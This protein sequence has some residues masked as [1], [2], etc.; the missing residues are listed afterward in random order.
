[1]KKTALLIAV[2]VILAGFLV[3]GCIAIGYIQGTG[4]IMTKTFDFKDFTSVEISSS[5]EYEINYSETYSVSVS[6]HENILSFLDLSQSGKTLFVRL[7]SG[8]FT[9]SDTKA[10]ITLPQLDR[11][12]V[13]GASRGVV[14]GFKSTNNLELWVSGASQMETNLESGVTRLEISGASRTNGTLNAQ[15]AR[16]NI[17]GASRAEI[18]GSAGR[19]DISISGASHFN[20]ED[21]RM[22]NATVSVSGAS[23]A[24]IYTS[25]DL[26][27][28]A[29]GASSIDYYGEPKLKSVDVSGASRITK[30]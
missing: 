16:I 2:M 18:N 17:S 1:M 24:Q 5:F 28:D 19:G 26:S 11:V 20:S 22:Q 15:E 10:K 14:Q 30:K 4:P 23:H 27:V 6:A 8:R 3:T 12:T 7:Q 13:S 25:G 9:N 21:F 29:T